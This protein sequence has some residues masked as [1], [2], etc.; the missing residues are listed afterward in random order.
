[1]IDAEYAVRALERRGTGIANLAAGISLAVRIEPQ[2]L[3][4]MR[5][6]VAPSADAGDEADL[7]FSDIVDTRAPTAITLH[8]D[9]VR[10]LR[11]RLAADQQM[12]H[13]AWRVVERVHG[14][15]SPVLL[16]EEE[17]TYRSLAGDTNRVSDLLRSA[18]ATLVAPDRKGL[19]AWAHGA[20]ARLPEETRNVEEAQMLAFG[21][22]LRL[23]GRATLDEGIP[24]TK[25]PEWAAWLSP[26]TIPRVV[27]GVTVLDT[28]IEFGPPDSP[29]A[30]RL[31]LPVTKPLIVDI[32]WD[33]DGERHEKRVY[34]RA[35]VV[36]TVDLG[37]PITTVEIRT[38]LGDTATLSATTSRTPRVRITYDVETGG[39]IEEKELPFIV[40]VLADLSGQPVEPLPTIRY[41]KFVEIDRDNFDAVLESMRPQLAL[42]VQGPETELESASYRVDLN[43]RR[44]ADFEPEA[45]VNQLGP[46]SE[47]FQGIDPE[48]RTESQL[49]EQ[50]SLL[51]KLTTAV[52]HH[53]DFQRLESTWRGLHYL[54]THTE[55]SQLLKIKV[56]NVRKQEVADDIR[57]RSDDSEFGESPDSPPTLE[58]TALF[59]KVYEEEFGLFGGT[60]F[61]MLVGDYSFDKS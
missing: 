54:V 48:V 61:G 2:L 15:I 59:K 10:I 29:K 41:R 58:Q 16:T 57:G 44:L 12:L 5:L 28:S 1:M 27:V 47:I 6:A 24:R 52:L 23:N 14:D 55:S 34:I 37:A 31:E 3:R 13:A 35:D 18:V 50:R 39:A 25:I 21:A 43:F 46:P 32:A 33:V 38:V 36:Q 42:N 19:A 30:Q 7:W 40:G 26:S 20:M 4:A 45:I 53:E 17:V 51:T 9:A 56:L 8:A 60:P 49:G 22:T 11:R